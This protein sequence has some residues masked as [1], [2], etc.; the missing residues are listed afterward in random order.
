LKIK[1]ALISPKSFMENIIEIGKSYPSLNLYPFPY[2]DIQET[3]DIVKQFKE[4]V[5]VLFFA[6]PIPY[7]LTYKHVDNKPMI[8]LP[9]NGGSLYR[10]LFKVF[11]YNGYS[12]NGLRFSIDIIKKEDVQER[13]DEL[14]VIVNKIVVYDYQYGKTTSD[15]VAF[16]YNLWKKKEV[17]IVL[18]CFNAV[19]NELC[20]LGVPC[21]RIMPTKS[22]IHEGF[23]LVQLEGKSAYLKDNQ[24]AIAIFSIESFANKHF[25][26]ENDFQ[27]RLLQLR[28]LLLD[29]SE[30]LEAFMDWNKDNEI[31]L[32]TTRGNIE[33]TTNNFRRLSLLNTIM[34]ELNLQIGVG[35]GIGH[36]AS[37]AEQKARE[38]LLKSKSNGGCSCYVVMYSGNTFGP[39]GSEHQ[40]GYSARTDD[41]ERIQLARRANLSVG[42]I[43]KII[44][45]CEKHG[46]TSI[47]AV[48]LANG[49]EITVRSARR[50]LYKLEQGDL[51]AI[52]G[53]EQPFSKGRPR[54]LY[55]LKFAMESLS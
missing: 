7:E 51:A 20:E 26:S 17:D 39:L 47:T 41:P 37:E 35:I 25:F 8:Y 1:V 42:T 55:H 49:F 6:G 18:T 27:M 43:N 10:V 33:R 52:V 54:Q 24:L 36:T 28:K 4:Y 15:I 46:R 21:Q 2:Q 44:S 19:Y 32:I 53:E 31:I 9:H 34:E 22:A 14:E 30:E 5:D 45:F 40:L 16:H 50:I 13:L 38:A 48:E 29:Y 11:E 3:P 12:G 23:R